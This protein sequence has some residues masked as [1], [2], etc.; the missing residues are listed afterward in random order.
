MLQVLKNANLPPKYLLL[1]ASTFVT[2]RFARETI[3]KLWLTWPVRCHHKRPCRTAQ[4][5]GEG[6]KK[7]SGH[8]PRQLQQ[9]QSIEG[10]LNSPPTPHQRVRTLPC[11]IHDQTYTSTTI[12]RWRH[13]ADGVHAG[14]ELHLHTPSRR[15]GSQRNVVRHRN[16]QKEKIFC[17]SIMSRGFYTNFAARLLLAKAKRSG[18]LCALTS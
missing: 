12:G 16:P 1:V 9:L 3:G 8:L 15:R 5:N 4:E 18:Q 13:E 2:E 14:G 17:S 6:G 7:D 11:L 10:P